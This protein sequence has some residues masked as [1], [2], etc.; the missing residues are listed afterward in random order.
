MPN[1]WPLRDTVIGTINAEGQDLQ[2]RLYA[3]DNEP[4][5]TIDKATGM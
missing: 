1:D 2:Y 5:F 3:T 4:R